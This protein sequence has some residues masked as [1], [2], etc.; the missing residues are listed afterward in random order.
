MWLRMAT[1]SHSDETAGVE[2][3]HFHISVDFITNI[4]RTSTRGSTP[5]HNFLLDGIYEIIGSVRRIA[6]PSSRRSLT[7]STRSRFCSGV[8]PWTAR[9]ELIALNTSNISMNMEFSPTRSLPL[10][11][12]HESQSLPPYAHAQQSVLKNQSAFFASNVLCIRTTS[13]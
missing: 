9:S 5:F 2:R 7:V 11:L 8:G 10:L 6:F 3:G 12:L 4:F 13:I 1:I